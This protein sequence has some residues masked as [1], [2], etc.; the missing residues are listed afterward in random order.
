M[1]ELS[2]R[3]ALGALGAGVASAPLWAQQVAQLGFDNGARPVA[4]GFPE[5]GEMIVQRSRAPLLETPWEVFGQNVFTPN[6]RF[7][8]RWH[9]A[10]IPLSVDTNAFRL[11]I[12]GAVNKATALSLAE[13]LKLPRVEIAAI[14]Q[15]SGNSRGFFTPRVAGAQWGHGAMGNARWTGVRLKDVLDLAGVKPGAVAVRLSGLDR[16]PVDGAPWF[17]KSLD[18]DHARDGEVMIAFAMNGA[19]LPMLNGFPIR[20]IVPGWYS[21]YWIKALDR[22]EVLTGPDDNF[23]MAKAYKIPTAPNATIVPGTKDFPATP[24]NRMVP[25]S[26]VTNLRDGATCKAGAPFSLV[27]LATGGASGVA[28]VDYRVDD[29]PWTGATLGIDYGRY[30]FRSWTAITAPLT[31]G[32]HRLSVRCTATDGRMQTDDPVWNPSGYQRGTIETIMV[33]AA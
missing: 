21:T 16:P 24:I 9:Y 15:C 14:N 30:S 33:R 13:L 11:R 18:V 25:R 22:I 10:D 1:T 20:L 2:R 28:R 5:K 6:D 12:G 17:A 4:G 23:W 32:P 26:F 8:V 7:Y 31:P 3:A 19:A 27:G 29:G